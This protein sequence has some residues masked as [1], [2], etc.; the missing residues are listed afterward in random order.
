[1]S[2]LE[3]GEYGLPASGKSYKL[4]GILTILDDNGVPKKEDDIASIIAHLKKTY[5]GKLGFEFD[6]I[7]VIALFSI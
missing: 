5:C 3:L 7:P 1:V 6:H 4:D 2:E